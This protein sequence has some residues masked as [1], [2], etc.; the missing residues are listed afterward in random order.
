MGFGYYSKVFLRLTRFGRSR[1]LTTGADAFSIKVNVGYSIARSKI[2]AVIDIE[3]SKD[4]TEAILLI[5]G[6]PCK[7]LRLNE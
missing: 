3:Y 4:N 1:D 5:D 7:T 6:K 2:L